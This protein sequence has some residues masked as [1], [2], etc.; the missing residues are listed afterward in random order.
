MWEAG[1]AQAGDGTYAFAAL[2]EAWNVP[3]HFRACVS[4]KWRARVCPSVAAGEGEDEEVARW[5][6]ARV[7]FHPP[8]GMCLGE[9]HAEVG[10]DGLAYVVKQAPFERP[11]IAMLGGWGAPGT[12]LVSDDHLAM[13]NSYEEVLESDGEEEGDSDEK[14]E[15]KE[16]QQEG[17]GGGKEEKG[18][19]EGGVEGGGGTGPGGGQWR[20]GRK[21]TGPR[22]LNLQM[23]HRDVMPGARPLPA[24]LR[25]PLEAQLHGSER[26]GGSV[27]VDMATRVSKRGALT[28]WHLDDGGEHTF[29]AALPLK[30]ANGKR[31]R[32]GR[33]GAPSFTGPH[34]L[35]VVKI[36]VYVEKGAYDLIVQDGEADSSRRFAGLDLFD[37]PCEHLP[38]AKHLP[39]LWL[40]LLE[41]GG[42]PLLA[43]PNVLHSV[44]TVADC[45]MC[46]QRRV[47]K[48]FLDEVA[49]FKD[50]AARWADPPILY[51][52]VQAMSDEAACSQVVVDLAGELEDYEACEEGRRAGDV[53]A[54]AAAGA[55]CSLRAV[56]AHPRHFKVSD[57]ARATLDRAV[58]NARRAAEAAAT[59]QA[60]VHARGMGSRRWEDTAGVT[61]FVDVDG[62][63][64][65]FAAYM[66]VRGRPRWGPVRQGMR[67]AR[68]D[69]NALVVAGPN[70]L[71]DGDDAL[72]AAHA[73]LWDVSE[74]SPRPAASDSPSTAAASLF[75]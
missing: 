8:S 33:R 7:P 19:G 70:S 38:E 25:W 51:T 13:V 46:E 18:E 60:T 34:G 4:P 15:G 37:T 55:Y 45:V 64:A 47:L 28:W 59:V 74:G 56:A 23:F 36:F 27:T 66:H 35:P 14:E 44:M 32:S 57:A 58:A 3:R 6:G 39:V 67:R 20:V 69:R 31:V 49:Y 11:K 21:G 5:L 63:T 62:S 24:L 22:R 42:P 2:L 48:T 1:A 65:G 61:R 41:A 68:L 10:G 53:S 73:A 75:D 71:D 54:L 52:F 72:R 9:L 12:P 29:Q 17:A 26:R 16:E 30:A 40:A 43:P 50:R